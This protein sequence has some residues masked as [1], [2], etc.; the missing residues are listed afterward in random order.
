LN[1]IAYLALGD[2]YTIGTG[3]SSPAHSFPSLLAAR[4]RKATGRKV[5]VT[6]PAIN[7]FTSE[8][9]IRLELPLAAQ[10]RPRLVTVLIG[11]NDIVQGR[12]EAAYRQSLTAIYDRLEAAR[13]DAISIPDFSATPA[14]GLFGRP[15]ALRDRIDAFNK[16][17]HEESERRGF[18]WIDIGEVSRSGLGRPGWL[19]SDDL[20]PGDAQ[21]ANWADHIWSVVG[22]AWC[23]T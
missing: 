9:L 10:I 6:N 14:A 17:G 3:A 13:V 4:L 7:G 12:S 2:S 5:E 16:A 1:Q 21:Y 20:H 19:A 15:A 18:G 8:D 23:S 22:E 11:A